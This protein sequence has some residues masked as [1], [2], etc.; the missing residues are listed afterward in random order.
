MADPVSA[1]GVH[2]CA[3]ALKRFFAQCLLVGWGK[4]SEGARKFRMEGLSVL[5]R[6]K[7][8]SGAYATN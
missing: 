4:T 5:R 1:E 6:S 7:V 8:K 3:Q 2:H